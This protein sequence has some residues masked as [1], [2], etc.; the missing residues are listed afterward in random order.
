MI[1][2]QE[3]L[4][5]P[6]EK[7]G[8]KA[9]SL[10]KMQEAGFSV[11]SFVIIPAEFFIA[12]LKQKPEDQSAEDFLRAYSFSEEDKK[13]IINSL[14]IDTETFSVRSSAMGEDGAHHSFAGQ[15]ETYLH[16]SKDHILEK[17]KEVWIS[18]FSDRITFYTKQLNIEGQ[19]QMAVVI[20]KMVN[21]TT[22]GV[23]FGVNPITQNEG[24]ML[25]SAVYGLGEGLVSGELNADNYY[26]KDDHIQDR[27]IVKKDKKLTFTPDKIGTEWQRVLD[28]DQEK[29]ALS[30]QQIQALHAELI[31]LNAFYSF[32]QDVEWA[33]ENDALFILQSRPITNLQ[34]KEGTRI[35]WDNSNII[36][37]YPGVTT[38]LTFSFIRDMYEA[39]YIQF[40]ELLGVTQK[41][42]KENHDVFENMLGL[43]RG[44]VYYNLLGWYKA[45]ALLPGYHLNAEFMEGMMGV[46]ERFELQS[47]EKPSK[48]KAWSRMLI[49]LWKM[50]VSF[51]KLPKETKTFFAFLDKTIA[52]YKG[53]D[54]DEMH[55][56]ILAQKYKRFEKILLEKWHPPLVNDFFAMIFFGV[57]Q[58]LIAK[59]VDDANPHLANDLLAHSNDIIS[60]LPMHKSLEIAKLIRQDDALTKLF[61][62]ESPEIVL[63]EIRKKDDHIVT[64]K[65]D[66]FINRFGERCLGELKLETISYTQE[67]SK[68]I[69]ILQSY[70]RN[71]TS[72]EAL[73]NDKSSTL[74]K[75]AQ[76]TVRTRLKRS[77]FKR[78]I[79]NYFL[80]KTRTL[81]SN[82][83]NLRFERTRGFGIVR[84][85]FSAMGK[86]FEKRGFIENDR[87]I[88]YLTKEEIFD[89]IKGTSISQSIKETIELRKEEFA[90][91]EKDEFVPERITT[92][93]TVY[94][95]LQFDQP[96]ESVQDGDIKGIACCAGVIRAEVCVI[97]SPDEI[98]DLGGRIMVTSSTDPGWVSLFPTASAILV[99]RGSLLSHSAI[100]ARELG[101]PCIVGITGLLSILK[102]GDVVEMDGSTGFVKIIKDE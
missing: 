23:M 20:Q 64:Q 82:R 27:E 97:H 44:R 14:P 68:Y 12:V 47:Q 55:P 16:V 34:I 88:F 29:P 3:Y 1:K 76:E 49:T 54:F 7:V 85:I 45:L 6:G 74:R 62:D 35:V 72:I 26:L 41:T 43:L 57:F 25:I 32:P 96:A 15:F 59:W 69:K 101:I 10:L 28:I 2:E 92:Y 78:L 90:H 30:D 18:A 60:V 52:E 21:A 77:P 9:E 38:P 91:Y 79:F 42:I 8:G 95:Q 66:N 46:K 102:T 40:S 13:Q 75:A 89:F 61:L 86:Q 84:T 80:R 37:S 31:K 93:G 22:S 73:E 19:V 17:V 33:Y 11:P 81:V 70:V 71:P 50:L 56:E 39:V 51:W 98:D 63:Q 24:E 48:S 99:E 67:P 94:D 87:D 4:I 83:E 53:Y 36:E 5:F 100:V 58:K 65:I